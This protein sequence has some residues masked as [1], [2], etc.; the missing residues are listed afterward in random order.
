MLVKQDG[1]ISQVE[2]LLAQRK[3]ELHNI[4]QDISDKSQASKELR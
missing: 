4:V 2:A 1:D 3:A